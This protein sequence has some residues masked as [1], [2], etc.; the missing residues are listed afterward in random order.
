MLKEEVIKE[1]VVES[2][3]SSHISGKYYYC[4]RQITASLFSCIDT[5]WIGCGGRPQNVSRVANC[6]SE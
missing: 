2:F 6:C 1:E 3:T 5:L 4:D